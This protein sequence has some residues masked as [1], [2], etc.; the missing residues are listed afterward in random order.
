MLLNIV[1][2]CKNRPILD[3]SKLWLV[4]R[5]GVSIDDNSASEDLCVGQSLLW[6]FGRGLSLEHPNIFGGLIDL[7]AEFE[8][9]SQVD[10][11]ISHLYQPQSNDQICLGK[12]RA[13]VP[14]LKPEPL[15]IESGYRFSDDCTYLITGGLGV[16]GKRLADWM[17]SC[18]AKNIILTSRNGL[19]TPGAVKYQEV[20]QQKGVNIQI[21]ALDIGN[22]PSVSDFFRGLIADKVPLKGVFHLAGIDQ[23]Q[24]VMD[25]DIEDILQVFEPKVHGTWH[26]HQYTL[27]FN[28]DLFVCFSSISAV[29]GSENRSHYGAANAF[30]DS[31]MHRRRLGGLPGLSINWGPWD[32]GGMAN[33]KDIQTYSKIGNFALDPEDAIQLMEHLILKRAGQKLIA[34]IDWPVF[35]R[36]YEARRNRPL[37]QHCKPFIEDKVPE[38]RTENAPWIAKLEALSNKDR[39]SEMIKLLSSEISQILGYEEVQV[40]PANEDLTDIG[41]DSLVAVELSI[42]IQNKLGFDESLAIYEYPNVEALA[43]GLLGIAFDSDKGAHTKMKEL[44]SNDGVIGYNVNDEN[45]ILDFFYKAWPKRDQA[46]IEPRWRWM[47]LKSAEYLGIQ[48]MMWSYKEDGNVIGFTGAIPV[49]LKAGDSELRS[50]WFVD[51]MVLESFRDK[52]LG[53][54]IVLRSKEDIPFNLSLGQTKEMRSILFKLGWKQI[55]P[56]QI[57]VYPLKPYKILKGKMNPL[58]AGAA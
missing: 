8:L 32:Q 14:R 10:H 21:V 44:K 20:L 37:I 56:L 26:L 33:P 30:I 49:K 3:Q 27:D 58:V 2:T 22:E 48:P 54:K 39:F 35:S 4:T 45:E 5:Q 47:Y 15:E 1:R 52:G 53:P 43:N 38:P 29:L 17:V 9:N 36:V 42:S 19:N 23:Q 7:S 46:F 24:P 40:L 16:L 41:I 34:D 18:G 12:E 13:W 57:Y 50:A 28:L 55:A 51:T 31:L 6:G 11:L 25:M